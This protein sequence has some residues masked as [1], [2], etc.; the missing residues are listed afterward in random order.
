MDSG[1]YAI[2]DTALAAADALRE[3][4]SALDVWVV[5]VGYPDVAHIRGQFPAE[6]RMI[7]GFV[8]ANREA[9][10]PL[11]LS[12]PEGTDA[13]SERRDRHRL[14]RRFDPAACVGSRS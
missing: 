9:I 2:A 11:S 1:D 10:V 14:Q 13:G 8:N 7:E 3:T 6:D 12:G 5:R 4:A